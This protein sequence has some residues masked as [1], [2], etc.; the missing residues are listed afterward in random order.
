MAKK[1][2]LKLVTTAADPSAPPRNLGQH[3][4][5]LWR[6]ILSEYEI[7]DA[8]GRELLLQACLAMDRA[9]QCAD[10]LPAAA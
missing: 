7:D 4:L 6:S 10:E 1:P 8:P 3:G 5:N 2:S 9:E